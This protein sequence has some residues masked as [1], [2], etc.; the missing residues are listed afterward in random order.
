MAG[1]PLFQDLNA[2]HGIAAELLE[3]VFASWI[4]LTLTSLKPN[5]TCI[6]SVDQPRTW[7]VDFGQASPPASH[8]HDF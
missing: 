4:I 8:V 7:L 6:N 3:V 5:V 2:K 1:E